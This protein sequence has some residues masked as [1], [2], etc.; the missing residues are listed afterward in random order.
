[1]AAI[2]LLKTSI[3]MQ[4]ALAAPVAITGVTSA[5]PVVITSANSFTG[6]EIVV[7]KAPGGLVELDN[8]QV[9]VAN[10]TGTT[11]ECE[12]LDG[13]SLGTYTSGGTVEEV[14]TFT[15]FNNATS[16]NFPEPNPNRID[17]TSVDRTTKV[18][19]FGL[20]DA[21]QITIPMNAD[22]LQP[23]VLEMRKASLAKT[24]R[25]FRVTLINGNVLIFNGGVAGGRGFDG[26]V[27]AV[28]TASCSVTLA[29]N[30]Q[31]FAS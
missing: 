30:E 12:G 19:V 8:L 10:P 4:S 31:W 13:T 26:S 14:T 25:V 23:H 24:N 1:M 3:E 22:P 21:P 2:L 9:R 5:N 15:S 17:V 29:A 11:F 20:D 7:L 27:G 6:G 28:A 18:E 16:F